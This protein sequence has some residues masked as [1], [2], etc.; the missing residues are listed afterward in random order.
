VYFSDILNQRIMELSAS[1]EL[2]VF[3]E[4]SNMANDLLIDPQGR[5]IA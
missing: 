1:G 2:S 4:R 5:L 3:R